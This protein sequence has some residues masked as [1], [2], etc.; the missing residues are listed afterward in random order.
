MTTGVQ[1]AAAGVDVPEVI[2]IDTVAERAR[3]QGTRTRRYLNAAGAGLVSDGVMDAVVEHLRREQEFGAYEAANLVAPRLE[4]A[5]SDAAELLG[6]DADEIAFHDAAT[7]GLRVVFDALRLGPGDTVIAPRS[8]Y[9]SQALRLLTLRQLDDVSL[10]VIENR[11]DGSIDLAAL[12]SALAEAP[13]AVISAVHVP[14]SSGLVEPIAEIGQLAQRYG[15]KYILDATQSVGQIDIDVRAVG[16]DVLVATGRKFLRGPRGTA[17]SYV[18]RGFLAELKPWAPDVR[19]STWSDGEVWTTAPTARAL[20]TWECAVAC[21]LGLAVALREALDRGM[22]ATEAHISSLAAGLRAA[23][24][25]IPGVTVTDPPAASAGIVTF[26]VDG[27]ASREVSAQLRARAIDTI[28]IP[29]S[30]AQWDLG[31]RGL[32][33]VVRASV[34]VY[35]DEADLR[36]LIEAVA[37]IAHA[38]QEKQQ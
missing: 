10:V 18:R 12:E 8:S 14:T 29:A 36:S 3:T 33:A 21:R 16:C 35:N 1:Q 22:A 5:Y 6:C 20:E 15:A 26:V 2:G 37:E 28:A 31:E 24:A 17:F 7:T 11:P 19:G 30:H 38:A 34:H 9:V 23:V 25:E 32:D 4:Q 13:G 27:L